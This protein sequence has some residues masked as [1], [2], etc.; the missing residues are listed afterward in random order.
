MSTLRVLVM[1]APQSQLALRL[2]SQKNK[3]AQ[4]LNN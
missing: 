1:D 3:K 4:M 2:W